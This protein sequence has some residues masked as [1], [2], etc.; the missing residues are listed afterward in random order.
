MET[1]VDEKLVRQLRRFILVL[2]LIFF[3]FLTVFAQQLTN[4]G[5][6]YQLSMELIDSE[7]QTK[8][9]GN[10]YLYKSWNQDAVIK[11]IDG[12]FQRVNNVNI[13]GYTKQLHYV[14]N[15]GFETTVRMILPNNV[16]YF[17]IGKD[18]FY[19]VYWGDDSWVVKEVKD[20]FYETFETEI[21]PASSNPM[22]NR[23]VDKFVFK[24][25]YIVRCDCFAGYKRVSKRKFKALLN[26]QK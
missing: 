18:K 1:R 3:G 21:I 8:I 26:E 15:D 17:T 12:E 13:D 23:P 16:E 14:V 4:E 6:K 24:T 10:R 25:I 22:V 9:V 7:I 2:L 5:G 11:L 19:I 20:G